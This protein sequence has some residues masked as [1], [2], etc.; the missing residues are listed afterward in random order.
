MNAPDLTAEP[1]QESA[2]RSETQKLT[3]PATAP[4]EPRWVGLPALRERGHGPRNLFFGSA[5]LFLAVL[6]LAL[7]IF[8][9]GGKVA[10]TLVT[11]LLTFA[12]LFV[13]ARL[14]ILRQRNGVFLALAVICLLGAILPLFER[15]FSTLQEMSKTS[16]TSPATGAAAAPVATETDPW[17]LVHAFGLTPPDPSRGQVVK[18]L[19]DSKVL[20]G[21]RHYLIKNGDLFP[22]IEAKDREVTFA[23]RDEHITLPAELVELLGEAPPRR[24]E[25]REPRPQ[26]ESSDSETPAQ[27]TQRAQLEAIRRYPALGVKGSLENQ[28]FID[29]YREFKENGGDAFFA[30]PGWPI[31]LAEHLAKR[32]GWKAGAPPATTRS[33]APMLDEADPAEPAPRRAP[34]AEP[35]MP[36]PAMRKPGLPAQTAPG[37]PE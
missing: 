1:A 10:L 19:K 25:P 27:I 3:A 36:E 14:H 28:A 17:P 30:D 34:L 2:R 31:A 24:T 6:L 16:R 5:A 35:A 13:L 37:L 23:V 12:A 26:L 33:G 11:C 22:F 8:L 21:S 20:I 18:V 29:V 4:F 7:G 15:A 32:E 9:S